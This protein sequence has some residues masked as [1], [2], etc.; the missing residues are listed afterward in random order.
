MER[1]QV[2]AFL[3]GVK[4]VVGEFLDGGRAIGQLVDGTGHVGGQPARI[5]PG[6][7]DN[8]LYVRTLGQDQLLDKVD[9][10]HIG[11]APQ[12]GGICRRL[13]GPLAERI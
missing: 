7:G 1:R 8:H 6:V 5:Q 9:E 13:E 11:I 4:D 12:L 3:D 10:L 2:P